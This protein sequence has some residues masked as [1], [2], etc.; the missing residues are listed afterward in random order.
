ET[1]RL[2]PA[3]ERWRIVVADDFTDVSK[4]ALDLGLSMAHAV[5]RS[6]L[7]H[8]HVEYYGGANRGHKVRATTDGAL[9]RERLEHTLRQAEER[10]IGRCS[11]RTEGIEDAGGT[12]RMEVVTGTVPDEIERTTAAER[13]HIAIFGQ[14]RIF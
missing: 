13:A 8:L 2:D 6:S 3:V 4:A 11:G 14:H 9:T 5:P 7:T 10:M 1:A 12:Y